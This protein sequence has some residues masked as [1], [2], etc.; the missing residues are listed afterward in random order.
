[1][2]S[3]KY[4]KLVNKTKRNRLTDTEKKLVVASGGGRGN[5]G[6]GEWEA[7]T[8]ECKIGSRMYC[9]TWGYKANIL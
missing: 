5:I 2:E 7:Q 6:V 4:N 3:K 1:M 8:T 9:T